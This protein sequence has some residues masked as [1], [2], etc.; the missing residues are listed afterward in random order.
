MDRIIAQFRSSIER[1]NNLGGLT[2]ALRSMTTPALDMSDIW[3]AQHVLAVSAL[4]YYIH[5]VTRSG[6]LQVFDGQRPPSS[7]YKKFRISLE[8]VSPDFS[9]ARSSFESEIRMQHGFLAFQHPDK[10]ADAIRLVQDIPLWDRISTRLNT[11]PRSVKDQLKLI[12]ERRNKIA[13][14]ADIDPTYP[15][16]RWPIA[17][18]DV[19]QVVRFIADLVEA[20]HSEITCQAQ[21]GEAT[22]KHPSAEPNNGKPRRGAK[23]TKR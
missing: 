23:K 15:G 20:L 17:S 21:T 6:M 14:E 19:E 5:E 4:D 8:S 2:H 22:A 16:V 11:D 3:R 10:I 18:S 1:V 9:I 12:V 7:A 13:H